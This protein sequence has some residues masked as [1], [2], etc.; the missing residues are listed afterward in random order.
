MQK[1]SDLV[2]D[3]DDGMSDDIS[4][5]NTLRSFSLSDEYHPILNKPFIQPHICRSFIKSFVY[6]IIYT[7]TFVKSIVSRID[8]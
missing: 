4:S 1:E 5:V 3:E 7:I 6:S 8:C 2:I